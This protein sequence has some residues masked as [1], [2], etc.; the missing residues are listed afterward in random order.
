M[1][2]VDIGSWI[3]QTLTLGSVG[4]WTLVIMALGA[5][6]KGLPAVLLAYD[7]RLSKRDER[8]NAEFERYGRL[9]KESDDRHEECR[10]ENAA[11]RKELNEVYGQL[12]QLRQLITSGTAGAA[13]IPPTMVALL[14]G[15]ANVPGTN[16]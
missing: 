1:T 16:Q 4:I 2:A 14:S 12:R 10:A 8:I 3:R 5:W 11:I 15:L 6:W 13:E 9:L 7:M